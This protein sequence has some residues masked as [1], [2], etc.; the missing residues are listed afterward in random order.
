VLSNNKEELIEYKPGNNPH[1]CKEIKNNK[2]IE[3][4]KASIL[5][6]NE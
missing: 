3:L 2:N 5:T 4:N 6:D 1:T